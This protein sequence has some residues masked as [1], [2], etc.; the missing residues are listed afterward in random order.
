MGRLLPYAY[1]FEVWQEEER[2]DQIVSASLETVTKLSSFSVLF[3]SFPM[4]P[5]WLTVPSL[6]Q[7]SKC[8]LSQSQG[9]GRV[10]RWF[11]SITEDPGLALI[12]Q[13]LERS[14]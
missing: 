11:F 8:H 2:G 12:P 6:C 3:H 5:W 1:S 7:V 4:Q 10:Q 14:C 13:V 9:V